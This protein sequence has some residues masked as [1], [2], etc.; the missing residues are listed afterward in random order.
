M[1]RSNFSNDL[2][3]HAA[4]N[5]TLGRQHLRPRRILN[6]GM[7]H[8]Q[9]VR[10]HLLIEDTQHSLTVSHQRKQAGRWHVPFKDSRR[11]SHRGARRWNTQFLALENLAN[12]KDRIIGNTGLGHIHVAGLENPQRQAPAREQHRVEWKDRDVDNRAHR[13]IVSATHRNDQCRRPSSSCI[14]H[15]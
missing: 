2:A 9:S 8:D 6:N 14:G 11:T 7:S 10:L 5:A 15:A 3:H 13:L 1:L 12:A 4:Q